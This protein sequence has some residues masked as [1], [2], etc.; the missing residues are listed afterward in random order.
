MR[1]YIDLS[2]KKFGL[3][4]AIKV[5]GKDKIGRKKW[6]CKCD[7][8]N[9]K[10]IS[11]DS[12]KR[13]SSKSCGCR[14]GSFGGCRLDDI[15]KYGKSLYGIWIAMKARCYNEKCNNYKNYGFRGIKVC[16]TWNN[17]FSDFAEDVGARPTKNHSLERILNDG[18][19]EPKNCRWAT[20]KEQ[21]RNT[22]RNV[23]INTPWGK[24]TMAEASEKS[25]LS[26]DH[27]RDK[28]RRNKLDEIIWEQNINQ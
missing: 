24:I 19:Y 16:D 18:D 5:S 4:T 22:R 14:Q 3:L 9:H 6:L 11:M 1:N 17:S 20:R 15:K 28:K 26:Y 8:G 25:G 2:G 12:L 13:G 21:C 10:E 7:C 27:I 23:F